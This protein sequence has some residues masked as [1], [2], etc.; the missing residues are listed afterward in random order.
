MN[1]RERLKATIGLRLWALRKIP[2]LWF[3]RP[4]VVEMSPE[5]CVVRVP[6][7]WRTR[8]HLR[9]MY[10]GAL[11]AGADAAAALAALAATEKSGSDYSILFKDVRAEFLRR[12]EAD[13]HFACEQG[14]EIAEMLQKASGSG[15]RVHLPLAVVATVPSVSGAEPVALF[16]MT[17]T[18]K[19]K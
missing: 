19:K 2:M 13:V 3:L 5:R 7:T 8:N 17:L 11:C 4:S 9:S 16:E 18:A 12:A 15:E 1:R 14:R 6:L 10:F